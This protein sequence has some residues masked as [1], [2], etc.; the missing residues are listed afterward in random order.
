MS[1]IVLGKFLPTDAHFLSDA[2]EGVSLPGVE[3]VVLVEDMDRV[4]QTLGVD[5]LVGAAML[6]HKLVELL[7][8][9]VFMELVEFD[10]LYQLVGVLWIRGVAT[11]L[12][13][14]CPSLV[15]GWVEGEKP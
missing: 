9:V 12:E 2:L 8:L 13:P 15:V 4:E 3:I 1:C 10:D 6:S 14:S 5:R 7:R 11:L